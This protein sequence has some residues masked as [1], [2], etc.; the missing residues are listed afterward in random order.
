MDY[1]NLGR[2]GLKVSRLCLGAMTYGSSSWRPWVLDEKESRPFLA[3]AWEEGINF[4]DTADMYSLGM[5]EEVVG[6]ALR[7]LPR[8]QVVLAT[9]LFNPLEDGPNQRGLGRKHVRH[10]VENSLRRLGMDY[11]DLY[12]IHR[13][14]YET[15][16]EETLEALGEL[17][18]EGKVLY[19]GASSMWAW[20][21]AQML[22]T[23]DRLGLPR[24]VSMQNHYNLLYREEEREMNRL[25]VQEGVGLIPWSPLARG[26]LA[27]GEQV[28]TSR[29]ETDDYAEILYAKMKAADEPVLAALRA[30]AKARGL[31]PAQIALAWL[32]A[33]PGVVAPIMGFSKL[34]QMD[35]ALAALLVK[36]SAEEMAALEKDYMPHPIA[37]HQ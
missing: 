34:R 10:A 24:F 9:K 23:S 6:R 20:Q 14:D 18:S 15:P 29:A 22:A 5:S 37:G 21:L 19:I 12:Q 35:D 1:V 3:R 27:R 30:V 4:F 31:P 11:I 2:S 32:L 33:K 13:F 17:V 25:C 36:L 28:L 26:L 16:I 8:E 7:E